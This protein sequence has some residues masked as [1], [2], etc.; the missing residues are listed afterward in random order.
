M[1]CNPCRFHIIALVKRLSGHF[2]G[3]F[4]FIAT[5][6]ANTEIFNGNGVLLLGNNRVIFVNDFVSLRPEIWNNL[7][8]FPPFRLHAT[9][10]SH[11]LQPLQ[12]LSP[13]HLRNPEKG[14]LSWVEKAFV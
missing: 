12:P 6:L 7:S 3:E 2:S 11:S 9:A 13:S 8:A 1:A 10:S 5:V 4:A 14:F